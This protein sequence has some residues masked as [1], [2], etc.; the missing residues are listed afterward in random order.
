M[1]TEHQQEVLKQSIKLLKSSKRLLIK[2]SAGT[3]KTFML[4][5]LIKKLPYDL[6]EIY[7]TAPTHK[8][9]SVLEGKIDL[10]VEFKTIHSALKM[11]KKVDN[12]TGGIYFEPKFKITKGTQLLSHIKCIIIDE[13]SMIGNDILNIIDEYYKGTVIFVGDDKQINPVNEEDSPVFTAGYPTVELTQIIRQSS[14]NPIIEL[15][16]DLSLVRSNGS[17][18]DGKGFVYTSDYE[19]ICKT[20][21]E[22]NGSDEYKYLAYHNDEVN[23]VNSDVRKMIYGN[24]KLIELGE[25]LILDEPYKDL[26]FNNETLKVEKLKQGDIELKHFLVTSRLKKELFGWNI[27]IK[28][29]LINDEIL[30]IHEDGKDAY[31]RVLNHI[32]K[33]VSENKLQWVDYYA[34][35]EL[36][37]RFKYAH[38]IT[39]HK[40]QGSTYKN[41]IINIGNIETDFNKKEMKRLLYTAITRASDMVILYNT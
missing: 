21:A 16:R 25:T 2:G 8:A 3:G 41:V 22:V 23:R 13:A 27:K 17:L 36:F 12:D 39:V 24:P 7:V 6:D 37:L 18:I 1:L 32:V 14:G 28:V 34:F 5:E 10:D 38:A 30:A 9:L 40:S 26:L 11:R 29:Y 31:Q 4:N 19:K 20:L 15:S 35:V 33:K